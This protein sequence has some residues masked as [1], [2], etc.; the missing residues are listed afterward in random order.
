MKNKRILFTT[1]H[2]AFLH[3]GGG[4]V[5]LLEVAESLQSE[6]FSIDIYGHNSQP[7][8][9]YQAVIHFGV[10]A[11]G[12]ELFKS[13]KA[14]GV[15]II[16]WP[17]LWWSANANKELID[18]AG[19]FFEL[20]DYIVFKSRAEEENNLRN[21][22]LDNA[23]VIHVNAGVD[24]QLLDVNSNEIATFKKL[25][26]LSDFILWVG[27]IQRQK[28]QLEAICALKN[29]DLPLVFIGA[30]I[31]NQYFSECRAAAPKKDIF[32][33]HIPHSSSMLRAALA[34]STLYLEIPSEPAGLSALEA[35][36]LGKNIILNAGDWTKEKFQH[37][38]G[39]VRDPFNHDEILEI[40]KSR[41]VNTNG[42]EI[43]AADLRMKHLLP[44]SLKSLHNL[45]RSF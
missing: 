15:P 21:Y 12:F 20:A 36:C 41:L 5:E 35:G 34:A 6:Y 29:F 14:T 13:I 11:D 27:V 37:H 2:G 18:A 4:E 7:I 42:N 9:S 1:Y 43:M 16:L 28:N 23:N 10:N 25:Y 40:V 24:P 32:I 3:P 22:K 19:Q 33:P 30:G 17:N 8:E 45:L 38:V 39:I 44:R 31:D 26:G